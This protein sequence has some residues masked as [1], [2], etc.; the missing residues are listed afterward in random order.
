MHGKRSYGFLFVRDLEDA[1]YDGRFH[2][3]RLAL[4]EFAGLPELF[5]I[6][7]EP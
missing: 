4:G 5:A 7:G 1:D 2:V 3:F 6:P